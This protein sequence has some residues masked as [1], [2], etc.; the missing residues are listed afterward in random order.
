MIE[1]EIVRARHQT[2]VRW[3]A[4]IPVKRAVIQAIASNLKKTS[5][6]LGNFYAGDA[7]S[8]R[9]C[10][11]MQNIMYPLFAPLQK[12]YDELQPLFDSG[13][14]FNAMTL[15]Y[16][17][18]IGLWLCYTNVGA[19]KINGFTLKTFQMVL[20]SFQIEDKLGRA[21]ILQEILLRAH[22]NMGVVLRM[23][24]LTLSNTDI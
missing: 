19:Q 8:W 20:A 2:W 16:A 5:F 17:W 10:G 7:G 9:R 18:K 21:Q 1:T 13:S 12:R 6:G 4:T 11:S 15:A 24:F 22:I 3:D 14:K 23:P